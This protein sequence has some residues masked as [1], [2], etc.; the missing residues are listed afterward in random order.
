ME[1][2]DRGDDLFLVVNFFL[3]NMPCAWPN[4]LFQMFCLKMWNF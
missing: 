3:V 2:L 1:A 4:W